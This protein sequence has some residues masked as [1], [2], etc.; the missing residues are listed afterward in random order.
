MHLEG[1]FILKGI[2][3]SNGMWGPQLATLPQ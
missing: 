2:L 1:P 3:R